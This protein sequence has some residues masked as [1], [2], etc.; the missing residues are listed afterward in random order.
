MRKIIVSMYMSLDG[1]IEEPAWTMPYFNEEVAK[2]QSDLLFDS[3]ALLLGRVTYEGFAAAWPSMTDEEGFADK[4]NSMPKYVTSRTLDQ[5]EW[6]ATLIKSNNVTDEILKLKQE[7]G[8]NLL[9]YGSSD[10]VHTLIQE[11]LI[12]EYHLIVHPIILGKGKRLFKDGIDAKNL[13]LVNSKT[14]SL[15]VVILSYQLEKTK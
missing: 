7:P 11:D 4:M 9:I 13:K 10:L 1:V 12:D 5:A 2:F 8:Q 3:E 6:N 15:G 14:T